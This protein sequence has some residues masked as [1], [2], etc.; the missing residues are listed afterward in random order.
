MGTAQADTHQ[1]DLALLAWLSTVK[2]FWLQI[3]ASNPS[4]VGDGSKT[5]LI[6]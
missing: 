6:L 4:T 1:Q 3:L 5:I 2:L